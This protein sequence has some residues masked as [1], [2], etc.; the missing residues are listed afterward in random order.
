[1]VVEHMGDHYGGNDNFA[2]LRIGTHKYPFKEQGYWATGSP[3]IVL[4]CIESDEEITYDLITRINPE[5]PMPDSVMEWLDQLVNSG[6][7]DYGFEGLCERVLDW[8]EWHYRKYEKGLLRD[9]GQLG[10]RTPTG[11]YML[12]NLILASMGLPPTPFYEEPHESPI[13]TPE[14]YSEYPYILRDCD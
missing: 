4:D 14:L 5:F 12:A 11:R 10:F 1:M 2:A 3:D 7:V 13:S 6:D 8:P 9:D